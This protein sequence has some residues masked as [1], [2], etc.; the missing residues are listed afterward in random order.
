MTQLFSSAIRLS[1]P[2]GWV[3][4]GETISELAGVLNIG[5]EGIMYIGAFTGAWE[6]ASSGSVALGFLAAAIAGALTLGIIALVCVVLKADQIVVGV[7]VNLIGMGGSAVAIRAIPS[8]GLAPGLSPVHIPGLSDVPWLGPVV[9]R[10]NLAFYGLVFVGVLAALAVRRT[11]WGLRLR[12]AGET[13]EA[14]D[15]AGVSV[16]RVRTGAL[17]VG[18]M[19]MGLGGAALSIG[20]LRG[21]TIN[22]VAGRGFIA[23]GPR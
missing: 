12:A 10:Q 1:V 9:F 23:L 6:A 13:P 4:L 15:V 19:L 21:F 8:A 3:A 11:T 22:M 2:V 20:D 5:L 16:N 14:T 18:G 7:G 17:L